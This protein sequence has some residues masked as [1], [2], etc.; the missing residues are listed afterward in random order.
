MDL[1]LARLRPGELVAGAGGVLLAVL[2]PG[3]HWYGP[4]TGWQVLT[5][6]RWLALVTIAAALLLVFTQA[7]RPAPALPVTL[8]VIV[9]VLGLPTVAWLVYRVAISPAAHEHVGSW[10]G[11]IS[12]CLIVVGAFVSMR[13]EGIAAADEPDDIPIV[14]LPRDRAAA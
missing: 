12:A 8:S 10:L 14:P 2:M 5:S 4:K 7:T 11:L 13:Q 9:F 3:V 6:A 1:K